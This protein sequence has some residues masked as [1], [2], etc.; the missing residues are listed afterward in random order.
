VGTGFAKGQADRLLVGFQVG[1]LYRLQVTHIPE[2]PG[3]EVFPTVEIIDRL[4]P[5]L[6]QALRFP[7]PIELTL[8]ELELAAEGHFVTRV[9]YL[10]DPL[11]ALPLADLPKHQRWIEAR[12]GEDPLVMADHLGRPVAI[13]RLGGRLPDKGQPDDVFLVGTPPVLLYDQPG[14]PGEVSPQPKR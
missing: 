3:L 13:L 10:E 12:L 8:E 11:A 4:Y 14:S 1:V 2:R 5:P 6:G 7:I 9:I